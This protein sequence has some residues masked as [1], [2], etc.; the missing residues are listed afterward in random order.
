M[1]SI[2][3]KLILKENQLSETQT[4]DEV[5]EIVKRIKVTGFGELSSYDAAIR[6]S[7]YLG[8]KPTDV[9]LHAG[10]LIGAKY[11]E[12]KGLIPEESLLETKSYELLHLNTVKQLLI[13][14]WSF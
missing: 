1:S 13:P 8:F 4:F 9:Y 11:L 12:D 6:I 10:T 14:A 7:T 2:A 5:Y 3:S